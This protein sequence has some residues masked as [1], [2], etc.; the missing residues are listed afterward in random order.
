M[1]RRDLI[2]HVYAAILSLDHLDG[3]TA[4]GWAGWVLQVARSPTLRGV[5]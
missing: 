2:E 5:A 4:A 1:N 3:E